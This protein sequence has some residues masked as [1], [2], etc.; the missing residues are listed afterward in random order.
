VVLDMLN[1]VTEVCAS[2]VSRDAIVVRSL[3][4]GL[5]PPLRLRLVY[6]RPRAFIGSGWSGRHVERSL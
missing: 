6:A 1:A 2:V 5:S 3:G 4:W